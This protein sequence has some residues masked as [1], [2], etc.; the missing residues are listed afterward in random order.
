MIIVTWSK[1][2]L[3]TVCFCVQVFI[4]VL[5]KY[6]STEIVEISWLMLSF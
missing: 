1:M 5:G 2:K 6:S 4:Q 3:F